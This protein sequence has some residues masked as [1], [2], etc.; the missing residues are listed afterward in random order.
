[1]RAH[2]HRHH[3]ASNGY[4]GRKLNEAIGRDPLAAAVSIQKNVAE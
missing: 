4:I 2:D 3:A 1:M